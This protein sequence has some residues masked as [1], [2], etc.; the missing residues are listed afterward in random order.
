KRAGQ[1]ALL[2]AVSE[3]R[4]NWLY[5]VVW[6]PKMRVEVE[7]TAEQ[8]QPAPGGSWLIF[9]D[10]DGVGGTLSR[11]LKERGETCLLVFP[12][13]AYKDSKEGHWWIDPAQ[14]KDF[15]RLLA[16]T[17]RTAAIPYRGVVHLW[18]LEAASGGEMTTSS[19]LKAQALGCGSVLHL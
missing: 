12:G 11:L 3:G 15:Q 18:G 8:H 5:E 4:N 7:H 6:R 14:P 2:G 9:A 10:A 17:T 13:D 19:L 1:E 16:E